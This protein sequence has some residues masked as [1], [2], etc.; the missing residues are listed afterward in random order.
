M[1]LEHG[2]DVNTQDGIFECPLHAA[3]CTGN[4]EVVRLL[5]SAGA[6]PDV[7]LKTSHSPLVIACLR[8][9]ESIV[10][11][12]LEYGANSNGVA[13]KTAS[14]IGYMNIVKLLLKHGANVNGG[15]ALPRASSRG[16]QDIV[17]LLI[18]HGA[19]VNSPAPGNSFSVESA[20]NGGQAQIVQLLLEHGAT[21]FDEKTWRWAASHAYERIII[22][23]LESMGNVVTVLYNY[24]IYE[25]ANAGHEHIVKLLLE[26]RAERDAHKVYAELLLPS[27]N[28]ASR[29]MDLLIEEAVNSNASASVAAAHKG[30]A[31]IVERLLSRRAASYRS[32]LGAASANGHTSIVKMLIEYGAEVDGKAVERASAAGHKATVELL[33]EYYTNWNA[34]T[35]AAVS[36]EEIAKHKTAAI[37]RGHANLT[38]LLLK[39]VL[40]ASSNPP[41][42]SN[43]Q[44]SSARPEGEGKG[45][46]G[47]LSDP[48]GHG[49]GTIEGSSPEPTNP[50]EE[51]EGQGATKSSSSLESP[52]FGEE[53]AAPKGHGEAGTKSLPADVSSV[54]NE[55]QSTFVICSPKLTDRHSATISG[56][57]LADLQT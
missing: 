11:L 23:L 8:N 22:L 9:D 37:H 49:Q 15:G 42:T 6:N 45:A 29:I 32:S 12:L 55:P 35:M 28:D 25:A 41:E 31:T 33:L 56:F 52:T 53:L 50:E 24:A 1:L 13:L 3:V 20:V 18:Q 27:N 36:P 16:H 54:P 44:E 7:V 40:D 5:L 30:Y 2:E 46:T 39:H 57:S 51:V 14:E 17:R 4:S 21:A 19:D 10:K 43:T 26:H 48:D 38:K 34:D 47:L